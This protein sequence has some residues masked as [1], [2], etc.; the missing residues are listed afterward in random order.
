MAAGSQ[1]T[2][3]DDNFLWLLESTGSGYSPP[4]LLYYDQLQHQFPLL[5]RTALCSTKLLFVHIR[6]DNRALT[7]HLKQVIL[8]IYFS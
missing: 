3:Q 1:S 2:S 7:S 8:F 6:K 4:Q 5:S